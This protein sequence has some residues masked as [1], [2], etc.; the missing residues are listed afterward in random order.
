MFWNDSTFLFE[1]HDW[2]VE[3]TKQMTDQE[4]NII[5]GKI[6][7]VDNIQQRKQWACFGTNLLQIFNYVFP[8]LFVILNDY[9]WLLLGNSSFENLWRIH[10]FGGNSV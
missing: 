6:V 4:D 7:M 1:T 5:L 9:L 8:Q 3:R 10:C 2:E